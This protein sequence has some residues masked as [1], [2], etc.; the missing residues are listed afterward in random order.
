MS[1]KVFGD[2]TMIAAAQAT[3]S[4][5]IGDVKI[6]KITETEMLRSPAGAFPNAE[7]DALDGVGWLRP[8]FV[9]DEGDLRFSFHA[10][11]IDT[12]S[13]R[14]LVDTCFGN[15]KIR[16]KA[17]FCHQ[18]DLPFL[19]DLK[20]AGYDRES[21]DT[22]LCTHLHTDHVGWNTMLVDG[23]WVPTFPNARYLVDKAEYE[24]WTHALETAGDE[25][26]DAML[27]ETFADSVKPVVDA[28]LIDLVA[29][30]HRICEEVRLIPTRGHTT[31]HVSVIIDSEG[32][33][34]LITGDS[35]HHPCQLVHV[36]WSPGVDH[37]ADQAADT[38]RA[39]IGLLADTPTLVI[40]THWAGPSAGYIVRDGPVHALTSA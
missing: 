28:G 7:P 12:G 32:Q 35:M 19:A 30:D 29:C 1:K 34:A 14:I 3:R 10:L 25:L 39:L 40:G 31:G 23:Q 33:R 24:H 20:M 2:I 9:S 11:V 8:D 36:H 4:W 17:A 18:L 26:M 37:D 38:R 5:Q 22:V 27:V 6:T 16:S 15:D 21:I 13:H